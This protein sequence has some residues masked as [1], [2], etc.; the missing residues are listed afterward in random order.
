MDTSYVREWFESK[1]Q[2]SDHVVDTFGESSHPDAEILLCCATSALASRMWPG[3][4]IDRARFVEFLVDLAPDRGLLTR[5]SVPV[6]V[7]KLTESERG[8]EAARLKDSFFPKH[9]HQLI[10]S[11]DVD[12]DEHAI[13]H[14]LPD[15]PLRDIRDS[16]FAGI[17]Y[18]DFRSA[19]VHEY[20]LSPYLKSLNL[21][22]RE[23]IPSYV[24]MSIAPDD[25]TVQE[26]ARSYGIS[27]VSAMSALARSER[28]LHLPYRFVREV[29]S[30]VVRSS[31]E[32]WDKRDAWNK[33]RP[34]RW[35]I[36]G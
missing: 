35:W 14:L 8:S 12:Q 31:L 10:T 6:L 32:Y 20:S 34:S 30:G 15:L 11:E 36:H 13:S 17:F 18:S 1:M 5:V 22:G 23:D 7:A 33:Q 3:P 19:L 27:E 26:F 25:S 29:L 16:S 24:N 28:F 2:V 21:T 4:G 9:P